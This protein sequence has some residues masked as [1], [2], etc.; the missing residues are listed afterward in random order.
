MMRK[1]K[2][3]FATSL[4]RMPPIRW[5]HMLIR[6]IPY[7]LAG[8]VCNR[9]SWLYQFCSGQTAFVRLYVML[10][11]IRLAFTSLIPSFRL[12]DLLIGIMGGIGLYAIVRIK[13]KNRKKYRTGREYGSARWGTAKDIAP[14][15]DPMYENNI[16]LTATE[17]LTMNSRPAQPKYARNK[18]VLVIGGSGSGKTRFYVKP[19]LMQMHPKCSYIVTDPKGSL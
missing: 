4:A 3:R 9:L 2:K 8:Y 6:S 11:N 15:I 10:M 17:R 12:Y 16:L 13:G 14:F 18:N 7:V 19:N 5:K 1:L